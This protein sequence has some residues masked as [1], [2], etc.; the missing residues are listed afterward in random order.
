MGRLYLTDT[1]CRFTYDP[2]YLHTG[3]PGLGLV[4]APEIYREHTIIRKRTA[5]FD[6]LPPIQ[7]LIPPQG[8]RNFQ[9]RLILAYLAKTGIVPARGI[10]EDWEIL[11]VAG[12][13]AIGH[14]DIF[15]SDERWRGMP[16]ADS[17]LF[18]LPPTWFLTE[19]ISYLV[20]SGSGCLV[21]SS[22][23][24]RASAGPYLNCW[25]HRSPA[26]TAA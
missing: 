4:Y 15:E 21:A 18:E 13:G 16:P 25:C 14:L 19:G 9:R 7:S 20:R 17:T 1:D 11:K 23:R 6:F 8:E 10:D 3:L 2:D 5:F 24:H 22:V 26:G 12:H